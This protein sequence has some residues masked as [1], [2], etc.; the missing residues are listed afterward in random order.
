MNNALCVQGIQRTGHITDDG[1]YLGVWHLE[2]QHWPHIPALKILHG[3]VG[4]AV[5]KTL[6]V[7]ANNMGVRD[8]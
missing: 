4:V 7:N 3:K 5:S 6:P 8:H 1:Q 2:A